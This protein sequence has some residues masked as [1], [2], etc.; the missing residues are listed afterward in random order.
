MSEDLGNAK[1]NMIIFFVV[2]LVGG[3]AAVLFAFG[4]IGGKLQSDPLP[5]CSDER[6]ISLIKDL[7]KKKDTMNVLGDRNLITISSIT[8]LNQLNGNSYS[9]SAVLRVNNEDLPIQYSVM[10]ADDK[11]SFFVKFNQ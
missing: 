10:V 8:T 6:T 5:N 3:V 2:L 9:C 1:R 11:K 4:G 7:L